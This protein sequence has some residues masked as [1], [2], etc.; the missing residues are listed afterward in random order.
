M[1]NIKTDFTE[2]EVL[3]MLLTED[4]SNFG[5][6]ARA[7]KQAKKELKDKLHKKHGKGWWL[8]HK[9][10]KYKKEYKLDKNKVVNASLAKLKAD[11][12][13]ARLDAKKDKWNAKKEIGVENPL[14]GAI[15]AIGA[16]GTMADAKPADGKG[17]DGTPEAEKKKKTLIIAGVSAV[18]VIAV[19]II[20][21]IK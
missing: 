4:E 16:I 21:I 2:D 6:R 11:K 7:R 17:G 9:Y 10:I 12:K 1:E 3:E 13:D 15:G 8:P 19:T 18:V 5:G 20:L 14:A